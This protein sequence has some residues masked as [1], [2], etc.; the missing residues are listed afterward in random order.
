[1]D[2]TY[3]S[4]YGHGDRQVYSV[5]MITLIDGTTK[6]FRVRAAPNVV[7]HLVKNM[8]DSGFLTL[9]NDTDTLCIR[10]D[11]VKCIEMR[12]QTKE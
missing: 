3:D 7:P 4:T 9:W 5:A 2:V 8:K 6:E 1:M 11:Q 12:E 10:A